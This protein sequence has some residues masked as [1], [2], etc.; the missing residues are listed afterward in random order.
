MVKINLG[1][2]ICLIAF[3]CQDGANIKS[4]IAVIQQTFYETTVMMAENDRA[5]SKYDI[6]RFLPN[7]DT[8]TYFTKPPNY[9][10]KMGVPIYYMVDTL[11]NVDGYKFSVRAG[12]SSKLVQQ[13][14]KSKLPR[15]NAVFKSD[16]LNYYA[17]GIKLGYN[18]NGNYNGE[19]RFSRVVFNEDQTQAC[20]YLTQ[21]YD[22]GSRGWGM[23][24]F[25]IAE[26]RKS[27]WVVLRII[28]DWT[29]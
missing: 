8:V 5:D 19:V 26:K 13:L 14:L 12:D 6:P 11:Y 28:N 15:I 20:Y 2:A 23:G 22:L 29:A 25:I 16:S 24:M 1:L 27:G 4:E 17:S 9:K 3:G 21:Y 18:E 10:Q 7:V